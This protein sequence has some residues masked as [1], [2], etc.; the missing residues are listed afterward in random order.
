MR[1]IHW[2]VHRTSPCVTLDTMWTPLLLICYIDRPDCAIPNAPAYTSEA[3]CQAALR[4]AIDNYQRPE[5][6]IIMAY[7]CYNWGVGS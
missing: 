3:S 1:Y 6:M 2:L 7:D 4:F 5:G